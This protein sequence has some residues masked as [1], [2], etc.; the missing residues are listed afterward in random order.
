MY[1]PETGISEAALDMLYNT[2]EENKKY[3]EVDSMY[4]SGQ[5]IVYYSNGIS[6]SYWP[7]GEYGWVTTDLG[8]SADAIF[9]YAIGASADEVVEATKAIGA[10]AYV[11]KPTAIINFL[12]KKIQIQVRYSDG[13]QL[14]VQIV[15]TARPVK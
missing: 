5:D 2:R 3:V 8:G 12:D 1:D 4:G 9:K 14:G 6:A 13:K 7:N 11:N 10:Y 15:D